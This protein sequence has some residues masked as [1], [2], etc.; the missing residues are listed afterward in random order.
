MTK[1]NLFAGIAVVI[2]DQIEDADAPISVITKQIEDKHCSVIK[3]TSLPK[4]EVTENLKAA[5]FFILDWNLEGRAL[6][7]AIGEV[8]PTVKL[9]ET[10]LK[11]NAKKNI[12]FLKNLTQVKFSP[13]FIFTEEAVDPIERALEKEGLK[14]AEGAN[15]IFVMQKADVLKTGVFEVLNA[16][17]DDV[18]SAYVLKKWEN[19]YY[20]A[21]NSFFYDFYTQSH[22]WPIVLWKAYLHDGVPPSVEIGAL[23]GRNVLS[24][25]TPFDFNL[26]EYVEKY[27]K[28]GLNLDDC[29][30]KDQVSKV[31]SGERFISKKRLHDSSIAPGDVFKKKGKYYLN[32]RPDCDCIARDGNEQDD[33]LLYLLTG[34]KWNDQHLSDKYSKHFGNLQERDNEAAVFSLIAG[35]TVAFGFKDM[36]IEPW[37]DWKDKREGRLLA[38]HLTRVQQRYAAYLQRP[39]L[40]RIPSELVPHKAETGDS[41]E[42]VEVILPQMELKADSSVTSILN[43]EFN[44]S[45]ATPTVNQLGST[46]PE[47][48]IST[49]EP[50]SDS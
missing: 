50:D 47:P 17:L 31:L 43:H 8:T 1:I 11:A 38:P 40:P 48:I 36:K 13:I 21:K 10:M 46:A 34:S 32:I 33:V 35:I 27:D 19:E 6:T 23:I 2:D 45:Q 29:L 18:P 24:R 7:E 26:K 30:H 12:N 16:W 25:M 3:F 22:N 41:G 42:S 39:G 15:N 14:S 20:I 37:K 4:N 5:S 9:P 49:I 44:E 28:Q